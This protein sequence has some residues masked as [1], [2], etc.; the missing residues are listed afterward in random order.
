MWRI[1]FRFCI[2]RDDAPGNSEFVDAVERMLQLNKRTSFIDDVDGKAAEIFTRVVWGITHSEL[3]QLNSEK[4]RTMIINAAISNDRLDNDE[5]QDIVA[6]MGKL[7]RIGKENP[8]V[9]KRIVTIFNSLTGSR[10]Q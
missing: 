3:Y 5:K 8:S 2:D 1:R 9:S 4:F 10:I 7:E 6:T